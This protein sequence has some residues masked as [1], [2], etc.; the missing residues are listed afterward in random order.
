M[1]RITIAIASVALL[2]ACGSAE[3]QVQRRVPGYVNRPTISPYVNLFQSNNGGLN[4]YFSFVRPR[5]R[6][7]QEIRQQNQMLR[8]NQLAVQR[9]SVMIQQSIE[10]A[11]EATLMQRPTSSAAAFRRPAGTFMNFSTFYPSNTNT[12]QPRR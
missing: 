2:F 7:D 1:S 11:A 12:I 6:L 5:L 9:E 8:D 4:S 3:A 10:Q